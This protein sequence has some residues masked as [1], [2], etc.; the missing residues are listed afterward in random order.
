MPPYAL[1]PILCAKETGPLASDLALEVLTRVAETS[2]GNSDRNDGLQQDILGDEI[3]GSPDVS[4]QNIGAEQCGIEDANHGKVCK[5]RRLIYLIIWGVSLY[6]G[7]G[8]WPGYALDR[9]LAYVRS[10]NYLTPYVSGAG[11]G[12]CHG[13]F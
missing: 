5:R 12:D 4:H 1:A 2:T 11:V 13:R 8:R 9:R 3:S 6:Q 7:C 10:T